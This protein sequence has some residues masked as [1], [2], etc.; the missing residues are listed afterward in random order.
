MFRY[1][2]WYSFLVSVRLK[3]SKT[4]KKTLDFSTAS[5][6]QLKLHFYMWIYVFMHI[7]ANS[8]FILYIHKIGILTQ[9]IRLT[10]A[11]SIS[12]FLIFLVTAIFII[13]KV[14]MG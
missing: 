4:V 13:Q 5:D 12:L 6:L 8:Y 3:C 11:S 14:I 1:L 2:C 9:S 7:Y 10:W